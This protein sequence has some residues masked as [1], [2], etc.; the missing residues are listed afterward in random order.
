VPVRRDQQRAAG[1]AVQRVRP[2]DELYAVHPRQPQVGRHERHVVAPAS[3][4]P[5]EVEPGLGRAFGHHAVVGAVAPA[6]HALE[7]R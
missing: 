5:E 2:L 6:Q 7:S 4:P 3:Q 1:A